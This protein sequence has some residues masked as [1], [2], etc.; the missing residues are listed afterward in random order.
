MMKVP[1]GT[2]SDI[3][4]AMT[5]RAFLRERGL[6]ADAIDATKLYRIARL[7]SDDDKVVI[8]PAAM[9]KDE[10]VPSGAV[11]SPRES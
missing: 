11:R 5:L 3:E 4:Q 1:R 2:V 7:K 8:A 6:D 10:D 9:E